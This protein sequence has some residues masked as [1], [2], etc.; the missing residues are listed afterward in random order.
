MVET[1]A[2]QI[3]RAAHGE[4]LSGSESKKFTGVS[5]NSRTAQ[6]DEVFF[7]IHGERFDGHDFMAEVLEKKVSGVV[8]SD[9]GKIPGNLASKQ[10]ADMPFFIRVKDTL[11][12]LQDFAHDYRKSFPVRIVGITGTNGKSTTK[13]M[14]A[15]IAAVKFKTLKNK[16]N[17]NN[18]IGLPLTL[19]D[20]D[21]THEVAV[22]EMGMSAAGEIR[23][24]AEIAG[25]EIG[26]ITNISEAHL[27][28]LKNVKSVQ[29]AKGELFEALSAKGTAIV[30]ADDPLVLELSRSLRAKTL[31]YGIDNTADVRAA[32]IRS[33]SNEGF[34]FTLRI[35]GNEFPVFLPFLGRFN[36]Y[37][38]LA[39][40][41]AGHSLGVGVEN[42][43]AGLAECLLLSQ[44]L[45]ISH[46]NSMT[47][48]NDT[49]NANPRSMQEALKLLSQYHTTG[50]RFFVIGDML[51]LAELA[52][53]A[54]ARIGGDVAK[55]PVDFL[56]TIG[57]LS[58][59]AG[60]SA[61]RAGM[62]ANRVAITSSYE[63]AIDYIGKSAR[64]GDCLLFKG[65]RGS[66]MEKVIQ[67]LTTS[68]GV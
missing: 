35:Q 19:F 60:E 41:A 55:H 7:C 22:L 57:P 40:I 62:A 5:I 51:E 65:S 33:R 50:R 38:A 61:L 12:A 37:N 56:I 30:N 6:P 54:H 39:A 58:G 49:Y 26:I 16:G 8:L 3:L 45:E 10:G 20:L 34:D 15:A 14:T 53:T 66:K 1:E 44:R 2:K 68:T 29:A 27:L 17:L 23:H 64:S 31:T 42:M 13:E 24:L 21:Q 43:R 9:A 11:A 47:F 25:P 18:H 59:L 46:H 67:G 52:E 36:V 4:L 48:I 28:T 63:E 32:D